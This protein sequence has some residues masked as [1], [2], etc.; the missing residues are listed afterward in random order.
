MFSV[1]KNTLLS[2]KYTYEFK[3]KRKYHK[4]YNILKLFF[5]WNANN[6]K[7]GRC[8]VKNDEYIK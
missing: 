2:R 8:Y 3:F 7:W 5:G 1:Q 4:H 6:S